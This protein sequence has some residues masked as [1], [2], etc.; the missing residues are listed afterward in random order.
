MEAVSMSES[1]SPLLPPTFQQ[2]IK[3]ME[4]FYGD[5]NSRL[6]NHDWKCVC[7]CVCVCVYVCVCVCVREREKLYGKTL[8]MESLECE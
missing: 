4:S 7:V 6:E 3:L 5:L 2:D 1:E 8:I